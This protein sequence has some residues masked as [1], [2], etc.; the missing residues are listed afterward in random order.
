MISSPFNSPRKRAGTATRPLL[1]I[2][3]SNRPRNIVPSSPGAAGAVH[4]YPPF[5][6]LFPTF[7]HFFHNFPHYRA[8]GEICKLIHKEGTLDD[9]RLGSV[10]E[11]GTSWGFAKQVR[12]CHSSLRSE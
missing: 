2:E 1:S 5:S 11:E 9:R 10:Y 7:C 6:P 8:S 3:C 4:S 12:S